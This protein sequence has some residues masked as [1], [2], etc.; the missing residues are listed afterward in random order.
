MSDWSYM[1]YTDLD[2]DLENYTDSSRVPVEKAATAGAPLA[3]DEGGRDGGQGTQ[4]VRH[5]GE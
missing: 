1:N 4:Q 2:L 5:G 3:G